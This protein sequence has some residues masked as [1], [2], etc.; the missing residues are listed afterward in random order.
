TGSVTASRCEASLPFC[1]SRSQAERRRERAQRDRAGAR[2]RSARRSARQ[3]LEGTPRRI[4]P[5]D[6]VHGA[7]AAAAQGGRGVDQG[8]ALAATRADGVLPI[9]RG[10]GRRIVGPAANERPHW[11]AKRQD[12]QELTR[13]P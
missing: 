11:G 3:H 6:R 13:D 8:T 5:G 1:P 4:G 12:L 2:Q 9:L 10:G 7:A